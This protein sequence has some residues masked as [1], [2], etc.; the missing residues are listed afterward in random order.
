M[1]R[2]AMI[3]TS[4]AVALC[5]TTLGTAG[6]DGASAGDL[7]AHMHVHFDRVTQIQQ[8]V[9]RGDLEATRDSARWLAEHDSPS[10]LEQNFSTYIAA[11]RKA[12][13][14]TL[15][16]KNI[17]QAAAGVST[18]AMACARCHRES[19][20][21]AP[22]AMVETLVDEPGVRAHMQRHQWAAD[23]LW[24]GLIG[25]SDAAWNAAVD[26]LVEVPLH[27]ADLSG[28]SDRQITVLTRRV[29]ELGAQGYV[30]DSI[31]DRGDLYSE[32]LSTCSKC[33][34][35]LGVKPGMAAQQ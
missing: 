7:T 12:A 31:K 33:H 4:A 22:F 26:M 30:A 25:P 32:F 5:A 18:M 1:L 27:P 3:L 13:N 21:S 24:E 15:A 17:D 14:Q 34:V 9:I 20:G 11:M 19:G 2:Q 35:R 8:S 29:H 28:E 16:A 23:R 6:D 10:G